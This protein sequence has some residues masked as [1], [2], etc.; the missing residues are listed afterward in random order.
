MLHWYIFVFIYFC[1][2]IA[3][4]CIYVFVF[5]CV[6]KNNRVWWR[7][8]VF[9]TEWD[10][11]HKTAARTISNQFVSQNSLYRV[12]NNWW[13]SARETKL[14]S[15]LSCWYFKSWILSFVFDFLQSSLFTLTPCW[16]VFM[17]MQYHTGITLWNTHH[18]H[19]MLEVRITWQTWISNV[20][21]SKVLTH[22]IIHTYILFVDTKHRL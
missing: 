7:E 11:A 13:R 19:F 6:C 1:R 14:I 4:I 8:R 15:K 18:A 2:S 22:K 17:S 3:Y 20:S 12:I 10:I 5:M 16:K 9:C 21:I